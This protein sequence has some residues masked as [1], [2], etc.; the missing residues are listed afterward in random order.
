M[1]SHLY[2]LVVKHQMCHHL[3]DLVQEFVHVIV[4]SSDNHGLY[5]ELCGKNEPDT[6]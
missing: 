5:Q 3:L 4:K 2:F 6:A 1:D